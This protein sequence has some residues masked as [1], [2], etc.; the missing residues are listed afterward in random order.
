MASA[1]GGTSQR[2]KPGRAIVRWRSRKPGEVLTLGADIPRSLI[3]FV[4]GGNRP[5][6]AA[7]PPAMGASTYFSLFVR[8]EPAQHSAQA[9]PATSRAG[10]FTIGA[11]HPIQ[12]SHRG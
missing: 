5:R 4:A 8:L 6:E 7:Q 10:R 3:L 12:S 2:V 11:P 1:A 9:S